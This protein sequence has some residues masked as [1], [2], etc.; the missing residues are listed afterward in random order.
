MKTVVITG[1]TAGLGLHTAAHLAGRG[2]HVV[3]GHRDEMRGQSAARRLRQRVPQAS[4]EPLH[5][6]LADLRSVARAAERLRQAGQRPPLHAIVGNAGIQVIDGVRRSVDGYELTFATNH[7]GHHLLVTALVNDLV[8]GGRI[9][10][11]SSGTHW[12]KK[13]MGF[14]APRWAAPAELADPQE[15]DPA[16]TAGRVRYATSKLAN[17]YFVHELARRL[18]GRP[19]MV[20]AYDPGLMPDTA[21]SR[22]YPVTVRRLYRLAAPVIAALVPGARSSRSAAR[23]LGVLVDDPRFAST[24]GAY[25]EGPK[26][27]DSSPESHDVAR[28]RELWSASEHLVGEALARR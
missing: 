7:L 28:E 9:V 10:L 26:V 17:I 22:D 2:W 27:G 23:H 25:L 16:P 12:P 24:T 4:V 5:I 15:A 8:D 3:L 1:A 11:V 18:A 13:S 21:L 20:N 19:I 6:D 14:P